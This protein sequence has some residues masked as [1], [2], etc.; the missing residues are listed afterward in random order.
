LRNDV[1]RDRQQKIA[2]YTVMAPD[3]MVNRPPMLRDI[4]RD[5]GWDPSLIVLATPPEQAMQPP[6]GGSA[7]K[8]MSEQSGDTENGP[9]KAD[10]GDNRQERNPRPGGPA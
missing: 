9:G 1:A 3:Q 5:F 2:A 6:H 10:S 8:H 7:N 4:A